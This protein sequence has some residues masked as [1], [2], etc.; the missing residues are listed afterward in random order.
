MFVMVV[1]SKF[2]VLNQRLTVFSDALPTFEGANQICYAGFPGMPH[3]E[4]TTSAL[5]HI[6][7]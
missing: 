1:E 3:V 7:P 4:R 2:S 6:G 5:R